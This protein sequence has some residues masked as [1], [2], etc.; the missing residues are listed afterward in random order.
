MSELVTSQALI[1]S[2]GGPRPAV[3]SCSRPAR[4]V[5]LGGCRRAVRRRSDSGGEWLWIDR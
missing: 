5:N 1:D 3:H 4:Q 2:A